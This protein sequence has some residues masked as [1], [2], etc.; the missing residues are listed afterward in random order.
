[1]PKT[2]CWESK[3]CGREPEGDNIEEAGICPASIESKVN[4]VHNGING[5]RCCWAIAG[6]L[7]G[8]ETQGSYA[9]KYKN[10]REC[11]FYKTVMYEETENGKFKLIKD[12]AEML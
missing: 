6:T 5:G 12:I 8:G 9:K 10:C 7:C 3:K 11:D 1:M 4:G 2:N